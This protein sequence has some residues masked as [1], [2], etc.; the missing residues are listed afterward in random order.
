M[1][2]VTEAQV[3]DVLNG[4]LDPCSIAAG[5]P[6]GMADMGMITDIQIR[7]DGTGGH[8]VGVA[9]GLTDPA[10]V[11]LGS[12]ANEARERL[13]GLSGVTAVDVTLDHELEWT[14]GR[15]APHYQRRLAEHRAE[16]RARL[17]PLTPVTSGPSGDGHG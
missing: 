15:L 5:V 3:R 1:G 17:L 16:R 2:A 12:F 6:A 10:C 13:T 11:L 9:I 7:A 8:R 14:P 4:I